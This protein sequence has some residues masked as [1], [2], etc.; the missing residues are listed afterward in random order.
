RAPGGILPLVMSSVSRTTSS[1]VRDRRA[2]SG[3]V[4]E[5]LGVN[6]R[7]ILT[8]SGGQS[9]YDMTSAYHAPADRSTNPTSR[10]YGRE[11]T[12]REDHHEPPHCAPPRCRYGAR[13]SFDRFRRERVRAAE[14]RAQGRRC[15][16]DRLP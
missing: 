3:C 5:R 1:P 8:P 9:S 6:L 11:Q 12:I 13:R 2:D 16:P 4:T 10:A 14:A 15:A 7:I